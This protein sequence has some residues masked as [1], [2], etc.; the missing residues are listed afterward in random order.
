MPIYEYICKDCGRRFE[1]LQRFG[2]DAEG[3]ACPAC[4]AKELEKAISAPAP[5]R[6]EAGRSD[7][8]GGC[9]CCGGSC[10]S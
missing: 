3:L 6:I 4:G 5:A 9:G 7:G 1:A 2:E 10:G 8:A